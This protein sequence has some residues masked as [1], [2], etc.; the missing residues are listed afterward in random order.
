MGPMEVALTRAQV[1]AEAVEATRLGVTGGYE[2]QRQPTPEQLAQIKR[3]RTRRHA[4]GHGRRALTRALLCLTDRAPLAA[5]V[6]AAGAVV[7]RALEPSSSSASNACAASF[8]RRR[9]TTARTPRPPNNIA[10]GPAHN[11]T[12]PAFNGGR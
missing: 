5:P 9:N 1:R 8:E 2:G 4:D 6:S 7:Q 3:G 12:V 10:A 11:T